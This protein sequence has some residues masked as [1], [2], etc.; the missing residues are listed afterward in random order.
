MVDSK[1][2]KAKIILDLSSLNEETDLNQLLL[3]KKYISEE[4]KGNSDTSLLKK[5]S[6]AKENNNKQVKYDFS[7]KKNKKATNTINK[8][9]LLDEILFKNNRKERIKE[10]VDAELTKTA[11]INL[12]NSE[13]INSLNE[14]EISGN[15]I[16]NNKNNIEGN[17]NILISSNINEIDINKNAIGNDNKDKISNEK[18]DILNLNKQGNKIQKIMNDSIEKNSLSK[19]KSTRLNNLN[20]QY[21][22]NSKDKKDLLDSD[23]YN[24]KKKDMTNA[25]DELS[26]KE[27]NVESSKAN[28]NKLH[29]TD[30]LHRIDNSNLRNSKTNYHLKKEKL[31]NITTMDKKNIKAD[32][33]A[34]KNDKHSKIN[35]TNTNVNNANNINNNNIESAIIDPFAENKE[36]IVF[37]FK[38]FKTNLTNNNDI[39]NNN[40]NNTLKNNN[41]KPIECKNNKNNT[42]QTK[43]DYF[44]PNSNIKQNAYKNL[45]ISN[46]YEFLS[47]SSTQLKSM[48]R[49]KAYMKQKHY[50]SLIDRD[51]YNYYNNTKDTNINSSNT[52]SQYNIEQLQNKN[53]YLKF[54]YYSLDSEL[55]TNIYSN[56][57]ERFLFVSKYNQKRTFSY[58]RKCSMFEFENA[59][60]R[61]E[62]VINSNEDINNDNTINRNFLINGIVYNN[63]ARFNHGNKAYKSQDY[64]NDCI[65]N[66]NVLNFLVDDSEK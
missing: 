43:I 21:T 24:N 19:D 57:I 47:S 9:L 42:S 61:D 51:N 23:N 8:D 53:K 27:N 10:K 55:N 44:N 20:I 54:Y 38:K 60:I 50:T 52:E 1:L 59:Y 22:I 6:K 39:N 26:L 29:K 64:E 58:G 48:L 40:N 34:T 49:M 56:P 31:G 13:D 12:I 37:S 30:K 15:K 66:E 18:I 35:T 63:A 32:T 17:N 7:G 2:I 36:E 62:C 4:N 65:I 5:Q 41:N 14:S 28:K 16:Y 33:N 25:L 11:N 3:F 45:S 46:K